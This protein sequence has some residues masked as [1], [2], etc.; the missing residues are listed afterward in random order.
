MKK[1]LL[2]VVGIL[3]VLNLIVMVFRPLS[4]GADFS[5]DYKISGLESKVSSMEWDIIGL[6]SQ[7]SSLQSRVYNL[8]KQ[9][10]E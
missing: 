9:L 4:V 8:E 5:T 2:V 6:Q 1:T 7:V 3:L 10:R